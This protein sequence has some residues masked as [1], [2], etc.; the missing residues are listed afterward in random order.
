[1]SD[2]RDDLEGFQPIAL[3]EGDFAVVFR[4][5]GETEVYLP[6]EEVSDETELKVDYFQDFLEFALNSEECR[7]LFDAERRKFSN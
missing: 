4:S 7:K 2:D 1:M 5:E 3:A 6:E